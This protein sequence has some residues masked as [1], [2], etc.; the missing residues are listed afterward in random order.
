MKRIVLLLILVLSALGPII[1]IRAQ[2]QTFNVLYAFKGFRGKHHG[3]TPYA[4]VVLGP[5]GS[6]YGTTA[7]GGS[8]QE[9]TVFRLR[10]NGHETILHSFV[11]GDG[12]QP[13]T[14]LIPDGA[15]NFYGT[16]LTTVFEVNKTGVLTVLYIFSGEVDGLPSPG[17]IRDKL[18][19]LYGTTSNGGTYGFG[20]V[21]KLDTAGNKT[22]LHSFDGTDG[23]SPTN[24]IIDKKLNFYGITAFGGVYNNG[25][26][27]KL[28]ATGT[29]T[30]LHSFNGLD[31]QNP[32][33]GLVR[34]PK[35][36][37]Y[38]TTAGGGV[39]NRGTVFK[40]EGHGQSVLHDFT[41]DTSFPVSLMLS[42]SGSLYGTT[43]AGGPDNDGTVFKLDTNGGFKTLHAFVGTDGS[44]PDAALIED[45]AGNLYGTT[46]SGG[47]LSCGPYGCGV[48]FKVTP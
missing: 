17:L 30:V 3:A 6:L 44:A 18:G 8:E 23:D 46:A 24:V 35:G 34:D 39:Y 2:A 19:N 16:T 40:M 29:F 25:T 15:G 43:L 37:L 14:T 42:A 48:V 38:G 33:G 4:A 20:T 10:A 21:F 45:G 1:P 11:Q 47:D 27:F 32:T 5:G 12:Y 26:V 22:I 28:G 31:G 41:A 9:G 7:F 13:Q 36:N